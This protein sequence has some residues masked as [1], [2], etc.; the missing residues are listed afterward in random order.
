VKK[1]KNNGCREEK[2]DDE[3]IRMQHSLKGEQFS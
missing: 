2:V 1:K 3:G